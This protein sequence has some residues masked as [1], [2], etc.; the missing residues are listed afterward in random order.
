MRIQTLF[1][2]AKQENRFFRVSNRANK[3]AGVKKVRFHDLRNTHATL[4]LEVGADLK[5]CTCL[6]QNNW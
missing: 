2:H 5:K 6:H 3:A 1:L 4:L